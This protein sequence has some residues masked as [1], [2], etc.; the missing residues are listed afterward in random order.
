MYEHLSSLLLALDGLDQD[1]HYHPEGDALYHSLQVFQ[2][3]LEA[4]TD[5]ALQAAALLHD[6][7]KAVD[8]SNHA[9]IAAD[10]LEGLLAPKTVWLI[11]HHMDLLRSP[12]Q[13]RRILRRHQWIADLERLRKWDVR[14]RDPYASVMSLEEALWHLLKHPNLFINSGESAQNYAKEIF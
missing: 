4:T 12:K 3:A 9:E 8:E 11:R 6:I 2:L 5:I 1:P 7:G 14:G 13:T 10:E